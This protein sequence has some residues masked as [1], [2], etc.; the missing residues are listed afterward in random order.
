MSLENWMAE[1]YPTPADEVAE[2]DALHHILVKWYGLRKS[3]L[4]KYG[5]Y[6]DSYGDIRDSSHGAR[7]SVDGCSCALCVHHCHG[8]GAPYCFSCPL[9]KVRDTPCDKVRPGDQRTPW[10]S[11]LRQQDP[12]PMI[13]LLEVA[14]AQFT[15][16]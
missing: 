9:Y 11:W 2:K 14:N 16:N 15:E 12:E 6:A 3:N 13:A 5:L 4:D 7:F 8:E 10:H 1:F